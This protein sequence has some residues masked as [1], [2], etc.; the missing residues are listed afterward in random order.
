MI[1]FGD[2]FDAKSNPVR[3]PVYKPLEKEL[4]SLFSEF[5]K[6]NA[7]NFIKQV[8]ADTLVDYDER[9]HQYYAA[10]PNS[11]N[12]KDELVSFSKMKTS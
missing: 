11:S 7:N 3:N 12:L 4:K 10:L 1:E 8:D 5:S 2:L 9:I 6:E